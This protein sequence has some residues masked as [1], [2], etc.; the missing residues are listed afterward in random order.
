MNKKNVIAILLIVAIVLAAVTI[1][2]NLSFNN[3]NDLTA[4]TISQVNEE[5]TGSGQVSLVVNPP[6]AG[7]P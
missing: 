2:L 7:N 6:A 1:V 5:A 3:D 4:N